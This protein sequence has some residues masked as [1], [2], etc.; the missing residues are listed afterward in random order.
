[1]PLVR[2][3]SKAIEARRLDADTVRELRLAM[4]RRSHLN[5]E[6]YEILRRLGRAV[7]SGEVER[8]Y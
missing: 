2:L 3:S 4:D 8:A 6:E 7:K 1:M 5:P